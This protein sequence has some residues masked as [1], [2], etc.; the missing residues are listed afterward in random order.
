MQNVESLRL[1]DC[2]YVVPLLSG[3]GSHFC[4]FNLSRLSRS[5]SSW[6]RRLIAGDKS[7]SLADPLALPR[8]FFAAGLRK[9]SLPGVADALLVEPSERTEAAPGVAPSVLLPIRS[10]PS[11]PLLPVSC[12]LFDNDLLALLAIL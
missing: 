1:F 9:E 12:C 3:L 10:N 8:R 2:H 11:P 5:R 6:P 4:L 7:D